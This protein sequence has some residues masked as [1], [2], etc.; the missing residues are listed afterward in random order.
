M[1]IKRSKKIYESNANFE[2]VKANK[3]L[4]M[5]ELL[6]QSDNLSVLLFVENKEHEITAM[7]IAD[8]ETRLNCA[9][10][11]LEDLPIEMQFEFLIRLR[12]L[13]EDM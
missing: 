10:A 8:L 2:N 13:F 3:I 4:E 1:E 12:D 5:R 11:L 6:S 9:W 7:M